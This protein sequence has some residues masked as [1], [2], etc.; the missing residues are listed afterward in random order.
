LTDMRPTYDLTPEQLVGRRVAF[1][2]DEEHAGCWH[3]RNG[4]TTGVVLR[5]GQTLAPKAELLGSEALELPEGLT[6]EADAVRLWVRADP[7][8]FFPRGC[9]LAVEKDCLLLLDPPG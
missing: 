8:P 2:T 6:D 1:K 3:R 5:P 9:E 4:F 7:S